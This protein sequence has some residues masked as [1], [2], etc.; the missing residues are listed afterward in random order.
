MMIYLYWYLGVGAVV[1]VLM[2]AF[3]K[4]TKK[5]DE[6]SLSDVLSDLRP[7]RKSLW[8][9]LLNDVLGPVLVGTLIV[10]FW[11]VLVFFK[12][13]EL[14]FGEPNRGPVDE[15]EFAVTRDA[16]QT[17]LSLQDIEQREIVFDPLGAAPN[18][19]FGH[20]NAA[21]KEFCNGMGPD[22]S[23]WSFTAHWTS[24]WGSKDIRQGYVIVR[25]EEIGAHFITVWKDIEEDT[26][27]ETG[28]GKK[29]DGVDIPA[30]LRKQ[31]D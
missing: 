11:P 31:A 8:F 7:E 27:Q 18:V 20:L 25:G 12:V 26:D 24:A 6:N 16:L 1:L 22:D 13:K 4:L 2:V 3:H 30:W 10:P 21:W 23:L 28:S 19:P 5:K 14:V 29:T 15:P 17:Q 9:R